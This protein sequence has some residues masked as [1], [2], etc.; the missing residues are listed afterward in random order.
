M[1]NHFD[2]AAKNWDKNQMHIQRTNAIANELLPLID[3]IKITRALEFG[4]GTGLL[5][6]L[7]KDKFADITLMDSSLEMISIAREKIANG[8]FCHLHPVFFDLE[9]E[10]YTDKTFDFIFTQMSLHHIVNIAKMILKFHTLLNSDGILTIADLCKEDGSF[11]D[12]NF[13]GHNG[14]DPDDLVKLMKK[15]GFREIN[16]KSC[17]VIKKTVNNGTEKEFPLFLLNAKK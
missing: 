2:E 17:F 13:T 14:F 12:A 15:N 6:L 5:S 4:A 1:I 7:L 10:N 11:H 9:K 8:G 16:Y 3:K